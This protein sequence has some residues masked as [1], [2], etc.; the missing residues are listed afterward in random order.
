MMRWVHRIFAGLAHFFWLPCDECGEFFGG[1][2]RGWKS[3]DVAIP[4]DTLLCP[5]CAKAADAEGGR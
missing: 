2:E 1:H 5:A 3:R 4:G